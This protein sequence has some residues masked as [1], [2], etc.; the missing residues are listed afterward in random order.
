MSLRKALLA[1]LLSLAL[2]SIPAM[3]M[4]VSHASG[5]TKTATTKKNAK[6][7]TKKNMKNGKKSNATK[8]TKKS[9]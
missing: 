9:K 4:P 2:F 5:A 3:A 8:Q 1:S 6:K 7:T